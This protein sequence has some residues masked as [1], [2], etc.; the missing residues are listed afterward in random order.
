MATKSAPRFWFAG[1]LV[2]TFILTAATFGV[3]VP[4]C[5]VPASPSHPAYFAWSG[6]I[7]AFL[8]SCMW[9]YCVWFWRRFDWVE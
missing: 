4:N 9:I 3:I 7:V 6:I 5:I 2:L 1:K 8:V